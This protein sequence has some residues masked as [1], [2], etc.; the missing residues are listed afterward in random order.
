LPFLVGNHHG[1]APL[2]HIIREQNDQVAARNSPVA[3][4]ASQRSVI[5][6]VGVIADTDEV[7][8]IARRAVR[9]VVCDTKLEERSRGDGIRPFDGGQRKRSFY[10]RIEKK[11]D[12][13]QKH[14]SGHTDLPLAPR[15]DAVAVY[16]Q[17]FLQ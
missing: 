9:Y 2:G 13:T 7:N 11:I 3:V 1:A 14:I 4:A 10:L 8:V 16:V 17:V 15:R 12:D 5:A 6:H